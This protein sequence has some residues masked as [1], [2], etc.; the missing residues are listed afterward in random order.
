MKAY[1]NVSKGG[2]AVM[3]IALTYI[4]AIVV[5]VLGVTQTAFYSAEAAALYPP[6]A[7]LP[8]SAIHEFLDNPSTL[9]TQYP[10]GG[11]GLVAV[12]RDLAASDPST[13]NAIIGLLATANPNQTTAIG[14]GLGQTALLAVKTD[15][16]YANAIQAALLATTDKGH[17]DKV[18]DVGSAEPKIGSTVTTKDEVAGTTERG[19]QPLTGGAG[20]Y[21]NELVR[22][23]VTGK[24]EF[25][26][27]DHT[28]LTLAPVTEIRLDQFV[29]N[30]DAA[31]GNV[32]VVASTGAFRFITG[33]QPHE[34]YQ[35]KTPFATMGVRGTQFIASITHDNEEIQLGSGE[36]IVTTISNQVVSLNTPGQILL[37]DSYGNTQS[38][39]PTNQPIINF[40]DLGPPVTNTQL[41]DALSAFSA[42]TGNT[43]IGAAG[44]VGGG[45]EQGT[46][47]GTGTQFSGGGFLPGSA[48]P[49]FSIAAATIP[50]IFVAPNLTIP[51]SP[52]PIPVSESVSP[53]K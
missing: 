25:L 34:D 23:G 27:A 21:L 4:G 22:T 14:T 32:V 12:V 44:G 37:V 18:K 26:F 24:A 45:A 29:Y 7:Q 48:T 15:Q 41:A 36:V 9:L 28:N 51:G 43:S 19:T 8:S 16:A 42:V 5:T 3:R 46:A 35:I 50:D 1:V 10:E 47:S 17:T 6:P 20:V 11:G 13:L 40:A 38:P 52:D 33:L 31:H 2:I 49:N 53:S 39:P 30:P